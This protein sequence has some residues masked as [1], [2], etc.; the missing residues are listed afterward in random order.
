MN[1]TPVCCFGEVLI[2]F[3]QDKTQ[4]G[5]FQRFAGG[6][7]AN[8]AVAVAR[9]GGHS[10]FIGMLGK[11]MFGDFLLQELQSYG[12]DCSAV[13]QTAEAKTA[14]AF[15]ALNEEGDR[16]FS[17]YRPP[18][19]D[20]LYKV[21]HCPSDLWQQKGILHLCSNSL[22]EPEIAQTSFAL[23][24]LAQQHGWL[25][26]VDANLRHNLWAEGKA[27]R[28]LVI[29]LLEMADLVKLS[30]DELEYLADGQDSASWLQH[31]LSFR[32]A[33]LVVTA[34]AAQVQSYTKAGVFAVPVSS[35]QVVDTTAAGD[36]FV[37]AWLYQLAQQFTLGSS[38]SEV[39]AEQSIQRQLI[40]KAITA[41][42]LTCQKFGA[43]AALPTAQ[44]WN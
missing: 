44:E 7:P 12:V 20:L 13:R 41:G 25:V 23:V 2:D 15:V 28:E 26:S 32:P 21:E 43:F 4:P 33:W 36:A 37:G 6:A 5:L 27:S 9:L 38:F 11:D 8:V 29:Q 24:R 19:A 40:E 22:T 17:F 3:L 39:L 31:I 14:L 35:V 10:K 18:A 42:S 34:G 30:E 1:A 16:S